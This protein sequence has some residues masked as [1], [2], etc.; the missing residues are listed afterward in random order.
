MWKQIAWGIGSAIMLG[1]YIPAGLITIGIG[2]LVMWYNKK[3][4]REETGK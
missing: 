3:K 1:I 2:L 4:S